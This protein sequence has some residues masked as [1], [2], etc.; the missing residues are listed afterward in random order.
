M[1]AHQL[2]NQDSGDT[3]YYTPIEIIEAARIVMGVIDLDPASSAIANKRVRATK[4]YTKEDDGLKQFWEGN[5]WLNHPFGRQLNQLWIGKLLDQYPYNAKQFINITFA[6]TSEKWF[7]PLL[8]FPQCY[9]NPR[10]NY[11]KPDGTIKKGVTKGSVI[12][13]GG[14]Y[15]ERFAGIFKQF[16]EIKISFDMHEAILMDKLSEAA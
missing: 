3:E 10:T 11:Y 5:I 9:L 16:G 12:T 15:I 14:P 1:K 7:K 6:A 2:I 13:Y 8:K 4:Y